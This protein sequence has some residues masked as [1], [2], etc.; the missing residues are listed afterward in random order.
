[1][2]HVPVVY[3]FALEGE[4]EKVDVGWSLVSRGRIDKKRKPLGRN[5]RRTLLTQ[6]TD[7]F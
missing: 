3:L 7:R 5:C 6:L 4:R 1:M 2:H